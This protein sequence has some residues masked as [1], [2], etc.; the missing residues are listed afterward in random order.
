MT[1]WDRPDEG[2]SLHGFYDMDR[3][4]VWWRAEAHVAVTLSDRRELDALAQ[5]MRAS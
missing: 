1:R 5:E 3:M 4:S 2:A